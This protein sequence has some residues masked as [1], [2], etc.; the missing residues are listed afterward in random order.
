MSGGRDPGLV[1]G[2]P[3][4]GGSLPGHDHRHLSHLYGVW[5]LEEINPYDTPDL[6]E[7]ARR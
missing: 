5:P 3:P 2:G 7:A 4:P 6:A 1:P